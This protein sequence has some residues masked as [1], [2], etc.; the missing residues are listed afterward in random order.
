MYRV[1]ANTSVRICA[2]FIAIVVV[3]VRMAFAVAKQLK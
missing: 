1:G 3:D 2:R